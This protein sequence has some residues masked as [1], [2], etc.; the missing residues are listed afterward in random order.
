MSSVNGKRL[1]V[2]GSTELISV[3]V[4]K[5]KDMGVYTIVTDNRPLEKAPAKQ[6]ADAYFNIDFSDVEAIKALISEHHIDGVLTGF[7]DSYMNYYL[8][9]CNET[10]LPCYGNKQSFDIATDKAIF[11]KACIDSKVPVIPGV[12]A[13]TYEDAAEF[14]RE[15]GFPLMLKPV[16]NSGSRGVIKCESLEKLE[17]AYAYALSFSTIGK[18]II[19]KYMDCDNIA[20]SYFAA[21]GEIRLSTTDDRMIYKSPESGASISSYSEYPSKYTDRYIRE[22]NDNVINMLKDNGF[23][24]GMISLQAFVDEDSFYFCEM[25]YRLSGGQHYILTK[26]Q[27]G[28]DQLALLIQFAVTGSC[29]DEWDKDKETPYFDE[30]FATLR[31][32]GEPGKVIDKLEGF[33]AIL[34]NERVIKASSTKQVGDTIGQSGTTAQIIGKISYKFSKDE[35]RAIVAQG[36]LNELKIEDE[37]GQSIAWISID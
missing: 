32:I 26:N 1:L 28:I 10:G 25:C 37:N 3:I 24:N 18:V 20:V 29:S 22:V 15:V 23:D 35:N 36:M 7:T 13:Y 19:E 33:D 9:I 30:R 14:S 6:I 5:A 31:I 21:D 4:K 12:T 34:K 17:S 8:T 27:N 2:L 11:K 16:D